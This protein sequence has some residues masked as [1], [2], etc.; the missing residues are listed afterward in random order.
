MSWRLQ[1]IL[2]HEICLI[3]VSVLN[4]LTFVA[5]FI[6]C[7]IGFNGPL[8]T[9]FGVHHYAYY[10]DL[11]GNVELDFNDLASEVKLFHKHVSKFSLAKPLLI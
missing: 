4:L 10:T 1:T 3:V 11:V 8:S 2:M 6:G 7:F 5:S 9:V